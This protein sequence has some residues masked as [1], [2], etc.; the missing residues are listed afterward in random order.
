MSVDTSSSIIIVAPLDIHSTST[1]PE[2]SE[3]SI[4]ITFPADV[5]DLVFTAYG[6][7]LCAYWSV[8]DNG[9]TSDKKNWF[10][11]ELALS[12]PNLLKNQVL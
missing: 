2:T 6:Q 4:N 10:V 12:A 1:G 7:F 5:F 11:L 3:K 9:T 8:C